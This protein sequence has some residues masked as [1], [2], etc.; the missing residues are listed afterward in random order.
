MLE[1]T[2]QSDPELDTADTVDGP[3]LWYTASRYLAL[4]VA[5]VATSGSL[6]FSEVLHWIPCSLCW[7]QRILMYPLSV[8]LAV[9]LWRRDPKVHT[10]VL[11][12]TLAGAAVALYHYMI[13]K[14]DWLAPPVCSVGVPCTVDYINWLGFIT[15]P[16]LALTAFLLINILML[17]AATFT[18]EP[19]IDTTV[20]AAPAWR[21]D[22]GRLAVV[23]IIVGVVLAFVAGAQFV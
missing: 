19:D 3:H 10:Y 14:S 7:Y 13:Q 5:W 4:L 8:V 21:L 23:V 1:V 11:P 18:G 20:Q 16:F 22:A 15:I 6:F 2:A 17:I 9:G 12:F